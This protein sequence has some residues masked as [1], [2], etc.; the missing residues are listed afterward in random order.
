MITA[1][2]DLSS[3][4]PSATPESVDDPPAP[5]KIGSWVICKP[6]PMR[7][8]EGAREDAHSLE[9]HSVSEPSPSWPLSCLSRDAGKRRSTVRLRGTSV[10]N[11]RF[12]RGLAPTSGQQSEPAQTTGTLSTCRRKCSLGFARVG[13]ASPHPQPRPHGASRSAAV[14]GRRHVEPPPPAPPPQVG[15]GW[16]E[17]SG[18]AR[19]WDGGSPRQFA[20]RRQPFR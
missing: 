1:V 2:G 16:A 7:A 3:D 14:E 12:S 15:A 10:R 4:A 13:L 9:H 20:R 8:A 6:E 5:A 18:Q 19:P 17:Q 11:R